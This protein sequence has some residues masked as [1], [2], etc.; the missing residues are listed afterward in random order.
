MYCLMEKQK[1][2]NFMW[3]D[4][5]NLKDAVFEEHNAMLT[6]ITFYCYSQ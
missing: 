3:T 1:N 4:K 2:H 5:L 6:A